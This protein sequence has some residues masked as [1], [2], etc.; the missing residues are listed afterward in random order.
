MVQFFTA[1]N[2]RAGW[3]YSAARFRAVGI[4]GGLRRFGTG[5][6]TD[7]AVATGSTGDLSHG[8]VQLHRNSRIFG[9]IQ[10]GVIWAV[11]G[12]SADDREACG[13]GMGD[14]PCRG[15]IVVADQ[16][17]SAIGDQRR[18]PGRSV[19]GSAASSDRRMPCQGRMSSCQ[20]P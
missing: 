10:D 2:F 12:D 7:S 4:S 5:A 11:C 14:F 15:R 8:T 18:V 17:V 6:G 1:G 20:A 3:L 16:K 13:G 9:G 19:C